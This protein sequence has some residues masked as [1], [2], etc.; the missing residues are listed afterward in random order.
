M[1]RGEPSST[2]DYL[3]PKVPR[4]VSAASRSSQSEVQADSSDVES[5]DSDL[6]EGSSA[7]L[8][9]TLIF[10]EIGKDFQGPKE[11]GQGLQPQL[12]FLCR[13]TFFAGIFAV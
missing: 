10:F 12:I 4:S 7:S 9:W 1:V 2:A 3:H 5:S 11:A 8:R 13:R 6:E